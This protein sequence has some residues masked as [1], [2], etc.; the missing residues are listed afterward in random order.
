[1]LESGRFHNLNA[2]AKGMELALEG[3]WTNGIRG[4][5]SYTLQETRN[6]SSDLK[7]PDS[8]EHLL[9]FNLSVPLVKEKIFAGLEFQYTSGRLSLH[10]T[11]D[12]DGQPLT[13]QGQEAPGFGIVNFTLFSQ[14]LIK[15]LEFSASVYNLLDRKYSDPASRFH[16]QDILE[17]DGRSFRLKLTYRF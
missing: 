12:A 10:N 17:R 9:K 2:E 7:L 11:T 5:I 14:N 16:Q 6:L 1:V 8:P 3:I 13:V 15:N 4:R